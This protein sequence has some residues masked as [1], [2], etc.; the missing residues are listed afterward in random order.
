MI[1][2]GTKFKI[3]NCETIKALVIVLQYLEDNFFVWSSP[4]FRFRCYSTTASYLL[5]CLLDLW[6]QTKEEGGGGWNFRNLSDASVAVFLLS[7]YVW[8]V[9]KKKSGRGY[10]GATIFCFVWMCWSNWMFRS[11]HP[12]LQIRFA[13]ESLKWQQMIY[14][15]LNDIIP[16]FQ[17]NNQR[18]IKRVTVTFLNSLHHIFQNTQVT[19]IKMVHKKN[20]IC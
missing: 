8:V 20:T 4:L 9:K 5:R 15:R 17:L 18:L 16:L 1:N 13:L 3:Q 12:H 7:T 11:V 2:I 19:S 14:F 10:V 6:T